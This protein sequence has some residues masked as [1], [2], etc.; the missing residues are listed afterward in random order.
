MQVI[1]ADKHN[2]GQLVKPM[3]RASD[4]W[5]LKPRSVYWEHLFFG[6]KSP[7]ASH[8]SRAGENGNT[9]LNQYLFN[10]DVEIE[11]DWL[12]L[13]KEIVHESHQ[14]PT[15]EHFYA[16]GVLLA[17]AFSFG[18][19]DLHRNN[20]V[21]TKTHLQAIDAEVV[22]ANISLP[23]ETILLPFK[24]TLF[25]MCG[26]SRI[27]PSISEV[28]S[29][30]RHQ[31]FSGYF[32]LFATLHCEHEAILASMNREKLTAPI[33]VIV[34]NT[35]EYRNHLS[36]EKRIQNLMPEE[37]A[38]LEHGDIPYFFKRI[39][40]ERLFYISSSQYAESMTQSLNELES[41]VARHAK[42]PRVLI[43]DANMIER[44]MAQGAFLLQKHLSDFSSHDFIW[45]KASLLLTSEG[46]EIKSTGKT[47]RK[48]K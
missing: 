12:G 45:N 23:N 11:Q 15:H 32:D 13:S 8:F 27:A 37:I 48:Q 47:F 26:L 38:Q 39:S 46:L 31:V 19:R 29:E 10:L 24:E 1:D 28:S 17:Y 40:D 42:H 14:I 6:K 21:L 7:I 30:S 5:F 20:L 18:I 25:D 22:L 34:R 36:G 3:E 9:P 16:F 4:C 2:F 35:R 33:R 43:G 44:K 41:D